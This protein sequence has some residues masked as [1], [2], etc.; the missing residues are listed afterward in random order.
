[1]FCHQ[2]VVLRDLRLRDKTDHQL[3]R[4]NSLISHR[5]VVPQAPANVQLET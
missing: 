2:R 1:M 4:L 3:T 5:A